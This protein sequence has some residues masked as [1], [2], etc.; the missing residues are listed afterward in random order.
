M[1]RVK[2]YK[3]LV[4]SRCRFEM[5]S[6]KHSSKVRKKKISGRFVEFRSGRSTIS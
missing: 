2:V 1:A 3:K 6:C 4:R 5:T